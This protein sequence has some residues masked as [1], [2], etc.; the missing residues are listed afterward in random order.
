MD[1]STHRPE[2]LHVAIG[3]LELDRHRI[4]ATTTIGPTTAHLSV[5]YPSID[6]LYVRKKVGETAFLR[7]VAHVVLFEINKLVSLSMVSV[8]AGPLAPYIATTTQALWSSLFENVWAQWRF[9]NNRP[10]MSAPVF[11]DDNQSLLSQPSTTPLDNQRHLAFFSGGKDSYLGLKLLQRAG[12]DFDVLA[13]T[14]SCY[15]TRVSQMNIERIA[16]K[17]FPTAAFHVF[18]VFDE[19]LDA[20]II[21]AFPQEMD[22]A[23]MLA[24]ETPSSIFEALPIAL[25]RGYSRLVVSNEASANEPNFY[26][27]A[28]ER[29]VNHQWGKS[30]QARA[31]L[32]DYLKSNLF[33][34]M[35]YYSP[36]EALSDP[37]IY[38]L[39]ARE[40][41][42]EVQELSSCNIEKPWCRRCAK[43][44]YV[45]L[46]YLAYFD[47]NKVT[48]LF[49]GEN[50]FEVEENIPLLKA[51]AAKTERKPFECVGRYADTRIALALCKV[52]GVGTEVIDSILADVSI[53]QIKSEL[54]ASLVIDSTA[55]AFSQAPLSLQELLLTEIQDFLDATS[56]T[57][58]SLL[59]DTTK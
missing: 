43:C 10:N 8:D 51:L 4:G 34:N 27:P 17:S 58:L 32:S 47:E 46:N 52:K 28:E 29:W 45:W 56:K 42:D 7:V 6:L 35:H 9:E 24:G 15:G 2:T 50:L 36:I 13:Y 5:W 59:D 53:D 16:R 39:L 38:I 1:Y 33:S 48:R 12:I 19:A 54:A 44:V 41:W 37:A 20:P 40:N 26:W 23:G 30:S 11:L 49:R 18:S 22:S 25:A 14:A 21:E 3:S 55:V 31:V 57:M